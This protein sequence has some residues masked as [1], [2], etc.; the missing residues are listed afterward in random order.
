MINR[1][2]LI[3]ILSSFWAINLE[4]QVKNNKKIDAYIEEIK[5]QYKIPG[6][7]L[8]VVKNGVLIHKRNY[9]LANIEMRVPVTDKTLFPLF[10]TTKVMSVVAVYQLIEQNKLSLENTISD[11]VEDLP[12]SWKKVKIKNLL[13]HSSGLPDIVGYTDSKEEDAKQKVYDD[14][15]KFSPGKQFD[16]NQTNFWLLN[17]I[18]QKVTR[19][20]LSEYI[21]ETQFPLSQKE[22]VFEGNNLKVVENLTYGYVNTANSRQILKRN[23]NFPEYEYGAAALNLTL[24]AF[25]EWNRKLDSNEFISEQTKVQLLKPF[26]YEVKRDFTYG[27]DFI[28]VKGEV[29]YGFSGGVSTAFR[30]FPDKKLTIILLANGMFIPTDK[31]NGINE[32]VNNIASIASP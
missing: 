22:S 1:F 2:L 29:S 12:E 8:A 18:V 24:D 21:L 5:K 4:A 23:W 26:D 6:L 14:T 30:K 17:R 32:V 11:F 10:S 25:V 7:A 27:L 13:T 28:K 19:K 31:L 3:L 9:G 20:K 16:Y 15:I